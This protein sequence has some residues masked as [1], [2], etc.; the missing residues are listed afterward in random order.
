MSRKIIQIAVCAT[1]IP[2]ERLE[3]IFALC[4]DGTLW[5][6]N[7]STVDPDW[8]LLLSVPQGE[9]FTPTSSSPSATNG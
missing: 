3:S 4:D 7:G 9:M 5:S 8:C 2:G 1:H 6:G